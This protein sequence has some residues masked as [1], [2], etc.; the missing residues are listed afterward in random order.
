MR[1][2]TLKRS[3]GDGLQSVVADSVVRSELL[4]PRSVFLTLSTGYAVE[5]AAIMACEAAAR[6]A[7][8]VMGVDGIVIYLSM[9]LWLRARD[10]RYE[11]EGR[12]RLRERHYEICYDKV[13]RLGWSGE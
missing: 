2:E 5:A 7:S 4:M 12:E 1:N 13:G 3:V 11:V 8:S 9:V 10:G 6:S